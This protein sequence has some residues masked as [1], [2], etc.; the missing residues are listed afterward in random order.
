MSPTVSM[1]LNIAMAV[2]GVVA[3]LTPTAFPEYIPA[4]IVRD[5]IQTAG[6]MTTIWTGVNAA[7]HSTSTSQAG[8]LSKDAK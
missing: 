4:G 1:Y 6:L 7:L 5:I 8:P 3:M 2:I